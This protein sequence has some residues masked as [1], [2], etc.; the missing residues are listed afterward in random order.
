MRDKGNYNA[1]RIAQKS[2]DPALRS[3]SEQISS[4]P[5]DLLSPAIPQ[6]QGRKP[7][8]S[9]PPSPRRDR[10]DTTRDCATSIAT[11]LRRRYTAPKPPVTPQQ[12]GRSHRP[13][14]SSHAPTSTHCAPPRPREDGK[15]ILRPRSAPEKSRSNAP[16]SLCTVRTHALLLTK[17]YPRRT[18]RAAP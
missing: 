9:R 5:H 11:A 15:T 4:T 13:T 2:P 7:A 12:T 3:G 18:R 6:Q 1:F 16:H 8:S 10:P 17:T 14:P